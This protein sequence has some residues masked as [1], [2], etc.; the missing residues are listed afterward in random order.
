M[1]S[2]NLARDLFVK[3]V[4]I[5]KASRFNQFQVHFCHPL[6]IGSIITALNLIF[7]RDYE[8]FEQDKW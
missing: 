4:R 2:F 1:A 6:T 3:V 8:E 7:A 5:A